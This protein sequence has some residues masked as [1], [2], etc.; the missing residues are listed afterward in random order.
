MKFE[1]LRKESQEYIERYIRGK[2]VT[3]EEA[4]K[5]NLIMCVVRD[6]ESGELEKPSN[7][8]F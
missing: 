2:P 3:K 4:M 6:I 5:N 7:F 1:D 8:G